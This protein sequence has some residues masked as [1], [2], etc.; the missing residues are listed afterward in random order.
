MMTMEE[1]QAWWKAQT[2][3]LAK[4]PPD[5]R[6]TQRVQAAAFME[7]LVPKAL[8]ALR[9][10]VE[11]GDPEAVI[12]TLGVDAA[13]PTD[14]VPD[15]LRGLLPQLKRVPVPPEP[16]PVVYF[17]CLRG[18][19]VYVGQT[20]TLGNR[21]ATHQADGKF[22]DQVFCIRVPKVRLLEVEAAYIWKLQPILNQRKP[23]ASPKID[24]EVRE[25][26]LQEQE[27][28][29]VVRRGVHGASEVRASEGGG[30]DHAD[31]GEGAAPGDD[32]GDGPE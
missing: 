7:A 6:E 25:F 14:L 5:W 19:V 22:F 23:G 11:K 16:G 15:Q 28:D 27:K 3:E 8:E 18:V 32:P 12:L 9:S 24:I 17:L 29:D 31:P 10:G 4:R 20:E 30:R 2:D 13:P 1:V 21:L 26:I